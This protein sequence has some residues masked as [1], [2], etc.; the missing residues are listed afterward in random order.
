MHF[1]TDRTA[2]TT[3]FDGPV[4]D[5]WLE[6]KLKL[7]MLSTMQDRPAMQGDPNLYSRVLYR[8]SYVP[9]HINTASL[10]RGRGVKMGNIAPTAEF[11]PTTLLI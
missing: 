10:E 3:A 8:L 11:E 1:P 4:V 5:Y 6:W 7:Q 9:P 2:H